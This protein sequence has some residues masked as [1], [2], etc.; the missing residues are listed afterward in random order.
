MNKENKPAKMTINWYLEQLGDKFRKLTLHSENPK[1]P[2]MI[3]Q[4]TPNQHTSKFK[5]GVRGETPE[6]ALELLCLKALTQ[7]P[8]PTKH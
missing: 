3:W 8:Y 5:S 1:H 2:K 6:D 7:P 4:A